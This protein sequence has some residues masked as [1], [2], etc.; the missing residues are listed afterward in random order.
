ML[1]SEHLHHS[2]VLRCDY[3]RFWISHS[4]KTNSGLVLQ[5]RQDGQEQH[6]RAGVGA[7]AASGCPALLLAHGTPALGAARAFST[8]TAAHSAVGERPTSCGE[9]LASVLVCPRRKRQR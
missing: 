8:A 3:K 5:R 9:L 6:L 1:I 7:A 2:I 4:F